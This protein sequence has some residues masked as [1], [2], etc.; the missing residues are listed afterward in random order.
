MEL[1]GCLNVYAVHRLYFGKIFTDNFSCFSFNIFLY[2][3]EKYHIA[4]FLCY[5][6][7]KHQHH[8]LIF[9]YNWVNSQK[10]NSSCRRKAVTLWAAFR[11]NEILYPTNITTF[12]V[13]YVCLRNLN[14]GYTL[15]CCQLHNPLEHICVCLNTGLINVISE[16]WKRHRIPG[17]WLPDLFLGC[18]F[19]I[20]TICSLLRAVA[21]LEQI[22]FCQL[23]L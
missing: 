13:I 19:S 8:L 9:S 20:S 14:L 3:S 6:N 17:F 1:K 22:I 5:L 18:G 2:G 7:I 10:T 12:L 16:G 23:W 21:A 11:L 15:H 4:F